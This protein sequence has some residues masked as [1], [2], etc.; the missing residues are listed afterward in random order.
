MIKSFRNK[1]LALVKTNRSLRHLLQYAEG[2]KYLDLHVWDHQWGNN[3]IYEAISAGKPQA[4]GKLGSV[5]LGA[6]RNYLRHKDHPMGLE[7]TA[8]HRQILFTNAGVFPNDYTVLG[9]Y[10]R[11]SIEQV[12]PQI[13]VVGVWFNWGEADVIKNYC[14]NCVAVR[15]G[16]FSAYL[17]NNP[18]TK[19]LAGQRVLV[20]HPFVDSISHQ[21]QNRR[22]I[23]SSRSDVLP[24]FELLTLKVPLSPAL[25]RSKYKD[26][27]ETLD[28]LRSE[29]EAIDFDI[30]L[31]GAGAYS[32]PLAV[33]AR[34]LQRIG[35][36]TGG[37]TQFFF[38][39]RGGRWDDSSMYNRFYNEHWIR[40]SAEETPPNSFLVENG[41]YW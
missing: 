29:M 18:W 40:P 5:E 35:I 2:L 3:Q 28:V 34:R 31:I 24:D 10:V 20:V 21:Y 16:S 15:L 19:A 4:I 36:H 23:W 26:W 8:Q 9:R 37:E 25:V 14:Q 11:L 6:I 17:W 30:A 22:N 1:G 41:C 32:L 7:A 12:L 38:G 33:H 27:F 39:I 13:T